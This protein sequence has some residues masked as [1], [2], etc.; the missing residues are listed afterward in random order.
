[1]RKIKPPQSVIWQ[2][3]FNRNDNRNLAYITA[4]TLYNYLAEGVGFS[5]EEGA[6]QEFRAL[7]RGY[8]HWASGRIDSIEVNLR[9]PNYCHVQ[10]TMRPSMKRGLYQVYL[11][12]STSA[13][14]DILVA[15]CE[16]AAG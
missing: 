9:N 7:S 4:G 8:T 13:K 11:L 2:V 6:F 5:S 16:C 12:L 15:T 1:M 3:E 14:P 10:C